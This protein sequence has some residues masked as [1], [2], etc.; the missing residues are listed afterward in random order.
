LISQSRGLGDVYKRQATT[1]EV[2]FGAGFATAFAA[3][4]AVVLATGLAADLATGFTAAFLA[5]GFA[6][7]AGLAAGLETALAATFLTGFLGA[8]FLDLE[9]T[10]M[11]TPELQIK[12]NI[13]R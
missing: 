8:G 1:F 2:A 10:G 3:G 11:E 9:A 12:T 7:A 5:T 13:P 6:L 4:L